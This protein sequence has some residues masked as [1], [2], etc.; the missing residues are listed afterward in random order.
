MYGD[1]VRNYGGAGRTAS[2]IEYN[3]LQP[4][5]PLPSHCESKKILPTTPFQ[6]DDIIFFLYFYVMREF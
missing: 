1:A 5:T 2:K 3:I 4:I 6:N